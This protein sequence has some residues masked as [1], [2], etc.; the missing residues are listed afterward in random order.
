[1][2]DTFPS[3][4]N[5]RGDVGSFDP[6]G[7]RSYHGFLRDR[8]GQFRRIDVPGAKGTAAARI[9]DQGEIVGFYSDTKENPNTATDIRGFLLD[10]TGRLRQD[11]S[12]PTPR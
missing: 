5:N 9:N 12:S 8:W 1:M 6:G 10:R 7:A 4:I 2:S 11:L 3:G